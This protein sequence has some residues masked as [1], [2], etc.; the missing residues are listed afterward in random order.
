MTPLGPWVH[1]FR[2]LLDGQLRRG[3]PL[4]QRQADG[5]YAKV[6]PDG[7]KEPLPYRD[8]DGDDKS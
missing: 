7:P 1:K 5:S 8:D 4:V 3:V 2:V 6:F